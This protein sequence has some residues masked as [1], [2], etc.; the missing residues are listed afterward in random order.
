MNSDTGNDDGSL[1]ASPEAAPDLGRGSS[2]DNL[3]EN[4]GPY[5]TKAT[6]VRNS[7]V[8]VCGRLG[9]H[10]SSAWPKHGA[11]PLFGGSARPPERLRRTIAETEESLGRA[12]VKSWGVLRKAVRLNC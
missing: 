4:E 1:S 11:S 9:S 6:L 8:R 5:R 12:L 7:T 10:P 3:L 2:D